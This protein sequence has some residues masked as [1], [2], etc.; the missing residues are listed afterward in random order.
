M[1][2]RKFNENIN[3]TFGHFFI[4]RDK[5]NDEIYGNGVFYDEEDMHN[6]LLNIINEYLSTKSE[7]YDEKYWDRRIQKNENGNFIFTD[8]TNAISWYER[9]CD[10]YVQII[11]HAP[12][13]TNV[14]LGYGVEYVR[15]YGSDAAI[16]KGEFNL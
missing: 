4:I 12:I 3:P 2:I 11:V 8:I 1:N 7:I 16:S 10:V 13:R 6:N 9:Y 14:K 15:K 5:D